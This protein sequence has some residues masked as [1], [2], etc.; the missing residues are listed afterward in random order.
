MINVTEFMGNSQAT[1]A[2]TPE[3]AWTTTTSLNQQQTLTIT[4]S[5]SSTVSEEVNTVTGLQTPTGRPISRRA[6]M[7]SRVSE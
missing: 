3:P 1:S 2:T 5:D 4:N 6:Y 7:I